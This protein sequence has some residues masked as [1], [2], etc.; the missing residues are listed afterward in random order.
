MHNSKQC[1]YVF[2]RPQ[3]NKNHISFTGKPF[4]RCLKPHD[5]TNPLFAVRN[6]ISV[7]GVLASSHI[8]FY[9][10]VDIHPPPCVVRLGHMNICLIVL[11]VN[12][13]HK[14]RF[15]S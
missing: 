15:L 5:Q 14:N 1:L 4:R 6:S 10:L 11:S 2:E 8:V 3:T 9:F 13:A 7:A 12:E